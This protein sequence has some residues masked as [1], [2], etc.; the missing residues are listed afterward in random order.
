L[1]KAL[2]ILDYISRNGIYQ[3]WQE[4]E[5]EKENSPEVKFALKKMYMSIVVGAGVPSLHA[6][7]NTL[8]TCSKCFQ[9]DDAKEA[10]ATAMKRSMAQLLVSIGIS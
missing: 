7:C 9:D 3:D 2:C 10:L 4:K 5:D 8:N 6:L 1:G